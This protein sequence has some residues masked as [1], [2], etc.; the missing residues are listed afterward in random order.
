MK[1]K[2]LSKAEQKEINDFC[3]ELGISK[4]RM[5][6]PHIEVNNQREEPYMPSHQVKRALKGSYQ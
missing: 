2:V 4:K 3:R 5:A 1:N 6:R